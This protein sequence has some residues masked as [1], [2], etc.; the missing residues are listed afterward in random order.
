M[1]CNNQKVNYYR[2]E[3][4]K[5]FPK[6]KVPPYPRGQLAHC[7]IMLYVCQKSPCMKQDTDTHSQ[8]LSNHTIQQYLSQYVHLP[9][10]I[11]LVN[12]KA[13]DVGENLFKLMLKLTGRLNNVDWTTGR[14]KCLHILNQKLHFWNSKILKKNV[15]S[16]I[17]VSLCILVLQ[18]D[19]WCWFENN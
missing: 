16:K 15:G 8:I 13:E 4:V 19:T 2:F 6:S 18:Q 11:Q 7:P 12:K 5:N 14:L 17:T 9:S 3:T 1:F 10:L